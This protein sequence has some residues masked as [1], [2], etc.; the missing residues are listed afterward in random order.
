MNIYSKKLYW[1]LSLLLFAIIIGIG[2]LLYTNKLVSELSIE[3]RKKI[4]LWAEGM[5][6][7]ASNDNPDQD[8][9]FVFE[10][11]R[12][13]ETVPVILADENQEI[14]YTRN[15]DSLK[16]IDST[17]M[18]K[19][20]VEMKEQN[21]PIEI[22]I[23]DD[24]KQYI[25]YSDSFLL[26][27]LQYYPLIQLAVIFLFILVAYLAFSAS[28]KAEQNQVWVGMSKETAHQ[29]GT[30]IS[31]L[32]AWI[33]LLKIKNFEPELTAEVDKD[34]KRLETIT[35]RFSKIGSAP[36]LNKENVNSVLTNSLNYLKNRASNRIIFNYNFNLADEH[37]A[38]LNI[39]L[40]DWVIENLIKNAI[41]AMEGE[42]TIDIDIKDSTQ[43][44]YVDIKDTGKGIPKSK[45][46]TIFNP[47]YTTKKRGW[48]LGLSLS[49]RIIEQYHNG[50][51]FVKNSDIN[52]GTTFRIVFKK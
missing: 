13:N 34:V 15:I 16:I 33:E 10:V 1:K 52:R 51:I 18:K 5:K 44:L 40:F 6:H 31:S 36:V 17:Y 32:L 41:D 38:P 19:L 3:E 14:I 37:I 25:Y 9:S 46:K 48:G 29:L 11:I 23:S 45:Y 22:V 30:P 21:E 35:E 4:E 47:G 2:S 49:K 39:P 26:L 24:I 20:L 42:G 50:K 7:M 8:L 12:N 27:Q 43:V 28:R